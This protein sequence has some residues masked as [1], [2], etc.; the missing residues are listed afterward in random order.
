VK[1][2][3]AE[4]EVRSDADLLAEFQSSRSQESFEAI[5]SRHG[6]A[7]YRTCLR[8]VGNVHDAEDG[9]QAVLVILARRPEA[10]TRTLTGWLHRIACRTA[11]RIVQGRIRRKETL[12]AVTPERPINDEDLRR[13]LDG[14]LERLPEHYREAVVLRYLEG[15]SEKEAASLA[16]CP[17]G[18]LGWRAMEG[19]NRLR[20]MLGRGGAPVGAGVLL[21][22]LANEA[23]ASAIPACAA[24]GGLSAQVS[25]LVDGG[26]KAMVVTKLKV[27]AMM[28]F[29]VAPALIGAGSLALQAFFPEPVKVEVREDEDLPPPLSVEKF[30]KHFEAVKPYKDE[31]RWYE[32]IPWVGTIHEARARAAREDKPILAFM[33]A[34]SPP[35]GAT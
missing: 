6:P 13:E 21:A 7:V 25:A 20:E 1:T 33:S 9:A 17:Q 23:A 30:S 19:L 27:A 15:R 22:F 29:A 32:D 18:T 4:T 8:I 10:V 16:G 11:W 3:L 5:V 14:A 34:N 24:G 26:L 35:L 2:L 12:R 31:W 28:V